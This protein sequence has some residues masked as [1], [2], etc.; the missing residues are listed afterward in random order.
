M[1]TTKGMLR[2]L[3]KEGYE[4]RDIAGQLYRMS[5]MLPVLLEKSISLAAER[6]DKFKNTKS[7]SIVPSANGDNSPETPIKTL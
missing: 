5:A 7:A 1:F 6:S 2:A 4:P 3:S